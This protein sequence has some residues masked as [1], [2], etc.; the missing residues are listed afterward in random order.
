MSTAERED[1]WELLRAASGGALLRQQVDG[2]SAFILQPKLPAPGR[3]WVLYAPSLE[4][5]YPT[6]R[7]A[8]IFSRLLA[9]GITVTGI[10][11]G[12]SYGS[13]RGRRWFTRWYQHVTTDLGFAHRACLVPQSRGGPMIYNWAAEHPEWVAGVTGIYTVCDLRSFQDSAA[14]A[15]AYRTDGVQLDDELPAHNP[16][17]RLAPLAHLHVPIFHIHGDDDSVVP[18]EANAGELAR[19]YR[20]LGG[21]VELMVVPGYGHQEHAVFF[22]REEVVESIRCQ[23]LAGVERSGIS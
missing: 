17:D 18:L 4:N 2:R 10:D 1:R 12:E 9:A 16:V 23:A 13:P 15:A 3:P 6:P 14:V 21:P 22:E 11:V 8:W 7:Q 20:A 19:R 5:V